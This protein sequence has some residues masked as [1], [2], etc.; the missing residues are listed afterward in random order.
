MSLWLAEYDHVVYMS[1]QPV[2]ALY[3]YVSVLVMCRKFDLLVHGVL[4]EVCSTMWSMA[5]LRCGLHGI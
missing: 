5:S 3:T 1:C 2:R 4:S